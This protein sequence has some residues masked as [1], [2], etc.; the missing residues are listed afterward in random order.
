[1]EKEILFY[2]P[3]TGKVKFQTRLDEIAA[4]EILGAV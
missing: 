4:K 3:L 1:M 2:D